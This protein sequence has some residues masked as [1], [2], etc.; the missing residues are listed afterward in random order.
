[1][2]QVKEWHTKLIDTAVETC[3]ECGMALDLY[4]KPINV[5]YLLCCACEGEFTEEYME[6]YRAA[7]DTFGL[8]AQA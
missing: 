6:G 7:L 4:S 3:P 8:M 2:T 1:M 5:R